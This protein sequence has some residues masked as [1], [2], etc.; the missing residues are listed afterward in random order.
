MADSYMCREGV[1]D[2]VYTLSGSCRDF[3]QKTNVGGRVQTAGGKKYMIEEA[4][5]DT[6]A[7]SLYPTA[8]SFSRY[9]TGA[10]KAFYGQVPETAIVYYARVEFLK[11]PLYELD[12]PLISYLDENRSRKFSN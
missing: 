3:I 1:Y 4:I 8:M 10:P 11:D 7:N 2:G 12:F 6:D 5:M 9:P